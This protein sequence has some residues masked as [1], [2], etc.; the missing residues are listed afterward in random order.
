MAST[1]HCWTGNDDEAADR[2]GYQSPEWN[3]A[4]SHPAICLLEAGHDGPHRFVGYDQIATL[5]L[6]PLD[7]VWLGEA[8]ELAARDLARR[9][10]AGLN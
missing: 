1:T 6:E 9:V 3:A 7:G 10:G 4:V 8:I 2:F 5:P